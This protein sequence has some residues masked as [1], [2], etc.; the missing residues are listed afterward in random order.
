MDTATASARKI[1]L[2]ARDG[3]LTEEEVA[4]LWKQFS[5]DP[6][7]AS[8]HRLMLQYIGLIRYVLNNLSL[9]PNAVLTEDDYIQFGI[10]G[11]NEALDRYDVSRGIKFE[12]Y[13]IP[14]IRGIIIDEVRRV[15]WLSRTARKRSQEFMQA[16]DKLRVEHGREVSSEEIRQ[17]LN[18]TPEEYKVYLRAAADATSS[19]SLSDTQSHEEGEDTSSKIEAIPDESAEN[20][21]ERMSEEE[22]AAYISRYLEHLPERQRLVMTLYYY[23]SLTFKEIGQLMKITESRV[24]QIH[25]AIVNDLRKK[26]KDY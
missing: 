7:P 11:L 12:T 21:L 25:T 8:K 17:K 26:L 14:R 15:D 13:A 4:A 22:R 20:A 10:I 2:K 9:A 18:L 24:C 5:D 3:A 19:F 16:A 6:T 1:A 23:E